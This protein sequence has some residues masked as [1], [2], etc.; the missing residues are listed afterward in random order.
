MRL[1]LPES[2]LNEQLII[3][4]LLGSLSEAEADRLDQLSVIDDKFADFLEAVENEL[5]DDY[6]R[7]ELP[8]NKRARFESHYLTSENRL[9]KIAVAR[10]L[11]RRADND[12]SSNQVKTWLGSAQ[13]TPS[14]TSQWIA[15]AA[16]LVM[17]VLAAYLLLTNFQ[18]Q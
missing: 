14:R 6:I 11:L 2:S 3:D 17:F 18:L 13:V 12:E 5:I 1:S 7:R 8:E 10:T 9:E 15:I 4:Y 16:A